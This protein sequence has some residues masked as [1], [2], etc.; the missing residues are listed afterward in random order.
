MKR[1]FL[2]L[3]VTSTALTSIATILSIINFVSVNNL[4]FID[5]NIAIN[6]IRTSKNKFEMV[7]NY[8]KWSILNKVNKISKISDAKNSINTFKNLTDEEKSDFINRLE[9]ILINKQSEIDDV[10]N[11]ALSLNNSKKYKKIIAT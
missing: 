3:L 5:K 11:L 1:K 8:K 9:P 4:N 2:S 10:I 6:D 7:D